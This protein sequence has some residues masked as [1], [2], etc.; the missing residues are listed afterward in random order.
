MTDPAV[1]IERRGDVVVCHLDDGKANALTTSIIATLIDV[2]R[3]AEGDDTVAA[4]VVHGR[5]GKLSGGF[6][7]SVMMG[8]DLNATINLVA[9]GGEL[10]RTF[11][12]SGV[13][14]VAA[15]TGHAVAAGSLM[16]LGCDVRIGADI[17]CK[18]GLNEV[19]IKMTLPDWA[20]TMA[21]ERLSR[22]HLQRSVANARLTAA[23]EAVDAGFLDEAVPVDQVLDV[24]V[25]RASEMAALDRAAY[26]NTVTKLRGD[27]LATVD[28]QIAADRAA[29]TSPV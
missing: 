24:A 16:L 3:D 29:T 7:L 10:V 19:A 26:R 1:R 12:G 18:I 4:V 2:V 17:D 25:A 23:S 5:E 28:A 27:V 14:V 21:K 6:D 13:P 20:M 22:R 8:D 15:C 9:D 11:Y